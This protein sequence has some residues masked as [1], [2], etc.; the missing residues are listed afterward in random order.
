[1]AHLSSADFDLFVGI[2][3]SGAKGPHQ[4]GL[5]VFSAG[6]GGMFLNGYLR[7]MAGTGH[8]PLFLTICGFRPAID[9]S[10]RG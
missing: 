10:W 1:M 8:A 6:R 3:W 5:S 7:L 2:D 4:P 9:V